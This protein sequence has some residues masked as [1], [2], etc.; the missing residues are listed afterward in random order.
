MVSTLTAIGV[1]FVSAI[2]GGLAATLLK[3][4][5][6]KQKLLHI[7]M[8]W[9]FVGG[10]LLYGIAMAMYIAVLSYAPVSVLYPV[11]AMSYIWSLLFAAWL[12]NERITRYKWIAVALIIL[13]V[14][15]ITFV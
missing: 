12:L 5:S 9:T 1:T 3:K 8:N 10:V 4:A 11:V 13:G 2:L 6:G 14:V 7:A 15:L